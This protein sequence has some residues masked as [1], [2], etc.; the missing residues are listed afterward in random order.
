[1]ATAIVTRTFAAAL[2]GAAAMIAPA[3]IVIVPISASAQMMED[4]SLTGDMVENFIKSYP[5]VKADAAA[6][7]KK[8][9]IQGGGGADGWGAW[10]AASGAWGELNGTVTPYGFT[11]FQQW[12]QVT[13]TVAK[14]YAFAESG[15][16]ADSAMSQ[17]IDEIKNNPNI[18]EAQK[19]MLLK[20]VQGS[21]AAVAGVRPSQENIDAV[22]PYVAELKTL[23]DS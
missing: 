22:A 23:F 13:M 9:N 14:A 19:E 12:L 3:S 8:H 7:G 18:P 6:I 20:Q 5:Q 1:M 10:M 17:A 15:G 11:D 16:E 4:A 21:M 2:L